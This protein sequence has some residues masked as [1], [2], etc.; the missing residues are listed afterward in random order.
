MGIYLNPIFHICF[1]VFLFQSWT[2]R[3]KGQ[4]GE[5]ADLKKRKRVEEAGEGDESRVKADENIAKKKKS[6]DTTAKLSAFAFNK[7]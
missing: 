4:S 7:N 2:E 1:L 6:L 3:A 5:A